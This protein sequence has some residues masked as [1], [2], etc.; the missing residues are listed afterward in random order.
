MLAKSFVVKRP[1]GFSPFNPSSAVYIEYIKWLNKEYGTDVAGEAFLYYGYTGGLQKGHKGVTP[2]GLFDVA[3]NIPAGTVIFDTPEEF[4]HALNSGSQPQPFVIYGKPNQ[5]KEVW[6]ELKEMGYTGTTAFRSIPSHTKH[7]QTNVVE[8]C[9]TLE[10]YK[11]VFLSSVIPANANAK[12][13]K[14]PADHDAVI[15]YCQEALNSPYW[16]AANVL[17]NTWYAYP[18]GLVFKA[19]GKTQAGLNGT[20]RVFYSECYTAS[21]KETRDGYFSIINGT[22]PFVKALNSTVVDALMEAAKSKGYKTGLSFVSTSPIS[23]VSLTTIGKI[24][25]DVDTKGEVFIYSNNAYLYYT[26]KWA[27]VAPPAIQIRVGSE[28]KTVTVIKGLSIKAEGLEINPSDLRALIGKLPSVR[29]WLVT[30]ESATFK[31]GC[32]EGVTLNEIK[33]VLKAYDTASI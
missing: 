32:W 7:I 27:S 21:G 4:F 11:E 31:I 30:L 6:A 14:L 2:L 18:D 28:R 13:F 5:L 15:Q 1:D 17:P 8:P 20:T 29:T 26:G 12:E 22:T 9:N 3:T 23:L 25:G 33:Q 16:T 24:Y 19:T 10:K